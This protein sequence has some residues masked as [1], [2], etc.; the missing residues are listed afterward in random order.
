MEA[1]GKIIYDRYLFDIPRILDLCSLYGAS[2]KPLL[3]KMV[4]NVFEKQPKYAED[5]EGMVR[6]S[7][8]EVFTKMEAGGQEGA[9]RLDRAG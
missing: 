9:V 3:A 2:N 6:G 1:F 7:V 5:W 8:M 4:E